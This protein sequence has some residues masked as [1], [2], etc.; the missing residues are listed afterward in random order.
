MFCRDQK[1]ELLKAMVN[2]TKQD[3]QMN[4][5]LVQAKLGA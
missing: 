5:W 3:V 2:V 1:N 4:A